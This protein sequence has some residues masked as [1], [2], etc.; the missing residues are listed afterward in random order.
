MESRW[1]TPYDYA[2]HSAE[3]RKANPSAA[4]SSWEAANG[5]QTAAA[6]GDGIVRGREGLDN[7]RAVVADVA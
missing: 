5:R 7:D 1:R 3:R 2:P 4:R 6:V